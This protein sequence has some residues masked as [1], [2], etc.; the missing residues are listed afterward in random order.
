MVRMIGAAPAGAKMVVVGRGFISITRPPYQTERGGGWGG[1]HL[2]PKICPGQT[3]S[4]SVRQAGRHADRQAGRQAVFLIANPFTL[5]CRLCCIY[6]GPV[7]TFLFLHLQH[8]A[9]LPPFLPSAKRHGSACNPASNGV[10]TKLILSNPSRVN[11][12]A[13]GKRSCGEDAGWG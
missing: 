4:Q 2:V 10:S 3:D 1:S 11:P 13:C 8:G 6:S 12:D 9:A 7:I 5:N